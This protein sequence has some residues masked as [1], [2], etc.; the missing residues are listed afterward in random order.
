[1]ENL[2]LTTWFTCLLGILFLIL[3]ARVIMQ[4]MDKKITFGDGDDK[5]LRGAIR[6]HMNWVEQTPFFLLAFALAEYR[7]LWAEWLI[8]IG[9]LFLMGRVVNGLGMIQ[10]VHNA[11]VFGTVANLISLI[12]I[13]GTLLFSLL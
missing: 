7:G 13:L 3:T 4:R 12:L 2:A 9:T 6:A 10:G 8:G 5:T 1:M 11:R